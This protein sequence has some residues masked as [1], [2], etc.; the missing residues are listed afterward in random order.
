MRVKC[1]SSGYGGGGYGGYGGGF[2]GYTFG[3]GSGGGNDAFRLAQLLIQLVGD[4][5]NKSAWSSILNVLARNKQLCARMP[6]FKD[7]FSPNPSLSSNPN[8]VG[9]TPERARPQPSST[10][11]QMSASPDP[12]SRSSLKRQK[13]LTLTLTPTL[14]LTR[15]GRWSP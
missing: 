7:S 2:G 10:G 8:L 14:T 5:R 4:Y 6:K 13:L 9:R 15:I 12:P 3:G 1:V 11:G